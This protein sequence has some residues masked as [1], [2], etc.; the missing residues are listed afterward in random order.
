MNA[1]FAEGLICK[2]QSIKSQALGPDHSLGKLSEVLDGNMLN[3]WKERAAEIAHHGWFWD[4]ILLN[5]TIDNVTVSVD[6]RHV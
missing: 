2:W 3:I 5:L 4:Y 6:G 1:K